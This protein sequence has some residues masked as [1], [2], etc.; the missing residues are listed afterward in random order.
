MG[1]FCD[2]QVVALTNRRFIPFAFD[3]GFRGG[4][5]DKAARKAVVAAEP[6][7]SGRGVPTPEVLF[8]TAEGKVLAKVSNYASEEEFLAVMKQVLIDNPEYNK[9]SKEELAATTPLEIGRIAFEINDYPIAKKSLAGLK[10]DESRLLLSQ[11]ARY[12]GDWTAA[13]TYLSAITAEEWKDDVQM[14]N[15]RMYITKSEFKKVI[16]LVDGIPK[17]SNRYTEAQY[18]KGVAQ[19][20]NGDTKLAIATWKDLITG[21]KVHDNWIYRADWAYCQ[22][23]GGSG[24]MS[25]FGKR[26]SLLGRIG[27][28]G[29]NN[30]DLVKRKNN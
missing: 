9:A 13:E 22:S 3:L 6:K 5:A 1:P 24:M 16:K 21:Q 20:Q 2:P 28:M 8:M 30:P 25:S 7:L 15:V 17:K 12:E 19:S 4:L 26:T 18:F 29:R 14:E 11:I 27:Y 23:L 10:S